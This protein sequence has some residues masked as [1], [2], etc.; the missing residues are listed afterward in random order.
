MNI[1]WLIAGLAVLTLV[2]YWFR[3]SVLYPP[4]LFCGM[5]LL[6]AVLRGLHL[7]VVDELH[8]ITLIVVFA[9]AALFSIGGVFAFFVPTR[10]INT[11]LTVFG[12]PRRTV[13]WLQY[14]MLAI[15]AG[16]VVLAVRSAIALAGGISGANGL[17]IAAARQAMI[18]NVNA[19]RDS[20]QISH[21][22]GTWT[23]FVAALFLADR[24]DRIAWAATGLAF[25]ACLVSGG[26]TGLLTLFSAVTCIILIKSSRERFLSALRFA[27]WPIGAFVLL[28]GGMVFV[29][30]GISTESGGL[31]GLAGQFALEYVVGPVTA[32]DRVLVHLG[33]YRGGSN[34]TFE[35]FL[36]IA[37]ALRIISYSPPP[38]LDEWIH[39]PF[40]TN[41]Y[42]YYRYIVTDFGI[43][44][45]V[46]LTGVVGFLHTL[47]FRKAHSG[48]LIGLYLFS[49]TMY[50]VLM[51]IFD[52]AYW[53]FGLYFSALAFAVIYY[54]ARSLPGEYFKPRDEA[55]S[56]HH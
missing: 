53:R 1:G 33:D 2:N 24:I 17:F 28:F 12:G 5:W 31:F 46:A 44:I 19:G 47:L 6:D 29:N 25:V 50:S 4:F 13:K 56:M 40:P 41:V 15:L 11:R 18:E 10:M 27:R 16:G 49:L 52:D 26:R 7:V 48:S 39:V 38:T 51:V 42:T 8:P 34:H 22:I 37:A 54:A 9:G 14:L 32:L 30:K 20:F 3:R 35:F 36:R 55:L 45:A 23:I 21:Y 43:V